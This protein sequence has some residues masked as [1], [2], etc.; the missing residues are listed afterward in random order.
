MAD[1]EAVLKWLECLRVYM[2]STYESSIKEI[3]HIDRVLS[4]YEEFFEPDDPCG[5]EGSKLGWGKVLLRL[6]TLGK[7]LANA[8]KRPMHD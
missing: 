4:N 6:G 1:P 5:L 3:I 2:Y 8:R 7:Q